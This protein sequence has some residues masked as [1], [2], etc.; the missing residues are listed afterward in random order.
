MPAAR[1]P[2]R[3]LAAGAAALATVCAGCAAPSGGAPA[4]TAATPRPSASRVVSAARPSPAQACSAATVFAGMTEAQRVGQLFIV[5]L[6]QNQVDG[7]VAAA[8]RSRHYGSVIFGMTSHAGAAPIRAVS[9]A[10]QSLASGQATG[11]VR[12]FVAANQEGGQVQALQGPGFPAIPPATAQGTLTPATLR[13]QAAA[14]GRELRSAGVNLNLAPVMDVVPPGTSQQNQPIGV[15][16]RN[17]GSD[18]A[19][20]GAHGV[21]FLQGMAQAGVATT[22]KHFPGLGR[23]RGNTD[24]T[25]NVVD[26]QTTPSDPSLGSFQAAI[27]ARV[28]FVMVALA[29]Y[30]R[31]D[32]QHLA[33]FSPAVMETMLRR[34]M[35]FQGVIVS[36]DLGVSTAVAGI[37]P[38]SRAVGFLSAGG[39]LITSESLT[40]ASAM[41]DAILARAA[42]SPAFRGAVDAAVMR[43]LAAKQAY[44]LLPCGPG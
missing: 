39:D 44:G 38:A 25:S 1:I 24:F 26:T 40:A 3:I 20:A 27:D 15:L 37:S 18:P 12:F 2:A 4:S 43:V 31:I 21:A 36:D 14:W 7:T 42:A 23:V 17:F 16:Q 10:V 13:Q 5:G 22:A 29:T 41:D 19:T 32:P 34:Q 30:T 11:G 8:I 6:G 28:P 9:A 35:H 33:V